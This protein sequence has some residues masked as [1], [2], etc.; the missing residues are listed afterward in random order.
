MCPVL[1][2]RGGNHGPGPGGGVERGP[3]SPNRD[4]RKSLPRTGRGEKGGRELETFFCSARK[5]R[6]EASRKAGP[7]S[8]Q[9]VHFCQAGVGCYSEEGRGE[10]EEGK[11]KKKTPNPKP[12]R[13][14]QF[15]SLCSP[16]SSRQSCS[17]PT[18]IRARPGPARAPGGVG[19]LSSLGGPGYSPPAPRRGEE[20]P[21]TSSRAAPHILRR[22]PAGS[23]GVGPAGPE[24]FWLQTAKP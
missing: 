13:G 18:K 3:A 1:H 24:R 10:R 7:L 19:S 8:T 5:K 16:G 4:L 14:A 23:S 2:P 6:S 22:P 12:N 15:A 17:L 11:E 21:C 20:L 9:R